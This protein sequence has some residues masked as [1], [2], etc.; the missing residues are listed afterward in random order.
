MPVDYD[1]GD[2]K[3]I[4]LM[5]GVLRSTSLSPARDPVIYLH[6][7]LG[8]G[9]LASMTNAL[10]ERLA[11]LRAR[12]D[13]VVFDQR[14]SGFS[15][16]EIECNEVF[17]ANSDA[18]F[19]AA[20]DIADSSGMNLGAAASE[21]LIPL[22]VAHLNEQGVGLKNYNT[23]TNARDVVRVAELLGFLQFQHLR[24]FLRHTARVGSA[25]A[26][27]TRTA[28]HPARLRAAYR[29]GLA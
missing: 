29:G 9:E 15:P 14:G 2:G 25:A 7:G 24:A 26:E 12:R 18:A 16:G 13:V 17:A 19:A 5:Y 28:L 22:C 27:P 1:D 11:T 23:V 6:G 10:A 4:D 3:T 8:G 20:E 21:Y